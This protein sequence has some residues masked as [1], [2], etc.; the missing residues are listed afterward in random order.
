MN[1]TA[2]WN[3]FLNAETIAATLAGLIFGAV[4][5]NLSKIVAYPGV[6][7]RAA[8]ALALLTGLLLVALSGWR[9]KSA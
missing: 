7:G 2:G 1:V 6:A 9:T 5:I 3:R 4:S 8:E